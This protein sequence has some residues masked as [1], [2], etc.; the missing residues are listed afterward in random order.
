M[1][2]TPIKLLLIDDNPADRMIYRRYLLNI[3]DFAYSLWEEEIGQKGIHTARSVQPDCIV[4]DY[5]LPD[6]DGLEVVRR[7][8]SQVDKHQQGLTR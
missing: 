6:A 3:S 8:R 1:S 2:S 7:L 4:V 5:Y